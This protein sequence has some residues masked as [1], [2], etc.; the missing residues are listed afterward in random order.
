MS[1]QKKLSLPGEV[2]E[3]IDFLRETMYEGRRVPRET[4]I[5]DCL[6]ALD[7]VKSWR[8][9]YDAELSYKEGYKRITT[10]LSLEEE[11]WARLDSLRPAC[12]EAA[13]IKRCFLPFVI[14]M[15]LKKQRLAQA[16]DASPQEE[17]PS[18]L[19]AAKAYIRFGVD[20]LVF[21]HEYQAFAQDDPTAADK[22]LGKCRTILEKDRGLYNKLWQDTK[23]W[24]RAVSDWYNPAARDR[25]PTFGTG[26]IL[27]FSKV[28]A[29]V[30][31]SMAESQGKDLQEVVEHL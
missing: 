28:L 23:D 6:E 12:C 25:G 10:T 1:V 7:G 29:G 26:N 4:V 19:P 22:L 20:L 3:D 2:L 15:V 9:V 24:L 18:V 5:H 13:G 30:V 17:T 14:K 31:L 21:K 16:A 27:F 8:D 11:D